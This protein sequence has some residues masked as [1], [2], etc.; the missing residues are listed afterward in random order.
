M[1]QPKAI[2]RKFSTD[3]QSIE[4]P[5]K[6]TFPFYYEPHPLTVIA[7]EELQQELSTHP[8]IAPLFDTAHADCLPTGKMFGVLIVK[9]AEGELGYLAAFSGKLGSHT[10]LEGY[11][12]L[13]CDLWNEEG[14]F[15]K[16][17]EEVN[18]INTINARIELLESD[19]TYTSA[20]TLLKQ[21]IAEEKQ[22]R[23]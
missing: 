4:L 1:S 11:V 19:P 8:L 23:E 17:G 20:K 3:V 9:N 5:T 13:I 14:F 21:Q 6:F 7:V 2:F 16:E 10:D 12:P 18:A 15:A 22:A